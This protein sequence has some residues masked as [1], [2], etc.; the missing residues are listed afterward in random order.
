MSQHDENIEAMKD[1]RNR[2]DAVI[3]KGEGLADPTADV[4]Y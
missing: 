3:N 4:S 1:I 2:L